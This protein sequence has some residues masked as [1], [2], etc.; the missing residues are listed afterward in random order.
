[1]LS[2]QE[3]EHI[4]KLARLGISEEEKE[5]FREQLSKILDYVKQ[6]QEVDVKNVEPV[7]QITELENVER[8]DIVKQ[9]NYKEDLLKLSPDKE[10]G[11][12]KVKA[13]F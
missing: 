3:V 10:D 12:F 5:K 11:Y 13:V 4:A 9:E 2:K 8:K 7:A 1:M 6:L